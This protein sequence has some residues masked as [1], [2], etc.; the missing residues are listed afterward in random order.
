[1]K[2]LLTL[3]T[4]T[5]ALGAAQAQTLTVWTHFQDE[6][7]GWLEGEIA[8]FQAAFGTE[9]ELVYVP[10][11]EIVQNMLLNAPEGQGPDLIATIPHDQLGQLAEA[12]V[13][14]SM[15]QFATPEYVEDLTEQSR[16]AF[17]LGGQLYGLPMYVDGPALIVNRDLVPEG[18]E[19]LEDML[20]TA[21]ELTTADTYGFLQVQDA[22]TFYHNYAWTHGLGGY[23]FGRD[24]EGNLDPSDIGLA[25]EGAVR[26]AELVRSLRY[27]LNLIPPGV[28]YDIMH[29][30]FL[31]GSAAMVV[32]GPW[33]IP[34]YVAAGIDVDVM[35]IPASEDGT[36][37]AG[38]MGVQ[39]VVLNE[40]SDSK[41]DAANL[42]K[43]LIRADAQVDLARAGGRIPA[44]QGAAEQVSDD[45]VIAGFAAAL[46]DAEPMPN[47]PEMGAVWT[48][49]QTAFALILES[50]DSDIATILEDAVSEIRGGE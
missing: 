50:P 48:P 45:P 3:F 38:F 40:F 41:I 25:N 13:L 10:V 16:L 35:P 7:L 43:W 6:S 11:N 26:A 44:S 34:D 32:N 15:E 14:A 12:G 46:A 42:A 33:A 5:L 30:Q 8:G 49:M 28:S 39:G 4:A 31:E 27:D 22:D 2:P 29:G 36:E 24:E 47:I 37:Y 18:P 1:M 9:V 17:T 20:A 23:V 21:Q 19:T